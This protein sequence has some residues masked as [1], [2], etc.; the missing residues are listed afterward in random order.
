M[1]RH[2]DLHFWEDQ[3]G[4]WVC[5]QARP[6]IFP[7]YIKDN[8]QLV[9]YERDQAYMDSY[10]VTQCS[11]LAGNHIWDWMSCMEAI[12]VLGRDEFTGLH[13]PKGADGNKLGDT[14]YLYNAAQRTYDPITTLYLPAP[15][16]Y[17]FWCSSTVNLRTFYDTDS[18]IWEQQL[19][20]PITPAP[21]TIL[22]AASIE[23]FRDG[24]IVDPAVALSPL[25]GTLKWFREA[26]CFLDHREKPVSYT[27][28]TLPTTPYV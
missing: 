15:I 20:T 11:S 7:D 28:L 26:V 13:F 22:K 24:K 8:A 23:K 25:S 1:A 12:M 4:G 14:V 2:V 6:T 27:H 5:K 16:S 19:Y 9:I 21:G 3:P 17:V 18:V 10:D